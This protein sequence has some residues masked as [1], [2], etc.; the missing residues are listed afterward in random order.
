[1]AAQSPVLT[2]AAGAVGAVIGLAAPVINAL[3]AR[4]GT[5][6]QQQRELADRILELFGE[7]QP[8][9]VVLG[10]P[11]STVRRQVYLLGERLDDT[12]AREACLEL[13]RSA[14]NP[15]A[16]EDD[17]FPKWQDTITEISRVSRGRR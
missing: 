3:T 1:M 6:R 9:V 5:R 10:G 12:A 4:L 11:H 8:L 16:T 2:L 7:A 15:G 17:I 13:V 14:G